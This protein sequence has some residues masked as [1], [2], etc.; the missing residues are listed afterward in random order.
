MTERVN[1]LK[2]PNVVTTAQ[3]FGCVH[4]E[5]SVARNDERS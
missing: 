1:G 5:P 4:T 2:L 3:L